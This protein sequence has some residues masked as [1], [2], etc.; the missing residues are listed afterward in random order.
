MAQ[1]GMIPV[2]ERPTSIIRQIVLGKAC[3]LDSAMLVI[4][5]E[6]FVSLEK[7]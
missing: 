5:K 3:P 4:R 2:R 7:L 6:P 1:G